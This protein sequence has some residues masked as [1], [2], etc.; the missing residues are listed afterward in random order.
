MDVNRAARIAAASHG[1]QVVVSEATRALLDAEFDLRD[2]GEHRLKDLAAPIRLFQL[3]RDEFPPL[4]SLSR[5]GLPVEPV[6][7]LGRKRELGEVL[8]LLGREQARLV[9]ITGS[10]GIGKTSLAVAAAAELV[11]SFDEGVLLVELAA[12][13]DPA[14]VLPKIAEALGGEADA[15]DQVGARHLLLVLD[16]LEQVVEAAG[17]IARL[18]SSCPNLSVLTTSRET[19]RVAGEREFPLKPLAEAPAVELFRQRAEAVLPH[20][21]ADYGRLAEICRRLDS[22][23]LAIELA[24]A[25]VKVLPPGELLARLDRRLPLLSGSRRDRPERQRTLRATIEWSY[26]LCSADEQQLFARLAVFSG[27]F[28]L[29]AAETVCE[30]DLDML[31]SLLDKS[32][33]R[34][35]GDRF[36]MLETI[37]EYAEERLE[38]SGEA[39]ELRRRHAE[40]FIALAE[41]SE[42]ERQGPG[43]AAV[44]QRFRAEWDNVRAALGWAL[45]SGETEVGLRLAGALGMVWLDQNVAVEGERW[46][47]ALLE[48]AASV[49]DEVRARA[50]MIG[51]TVAGVRSNF[52]QAAL[53]GEESLTHFRATGSELGIAWGLTTMAVLALERGAPEA[54][55]QMLEEAEALHRKLGNPGGV[56]R[57]LHLQGQQAA[58][59]GDVDRGR[60][61]LREVTDLSVEA[62]DQFSAASI[63][64]SLGD[65]D[66]A[67][68]DLGAAEEDYRHALRVAW[69]SRADRLVCYCL[70]GL[71][72]VAAE[73]GDAKRAALLWGFADAYEERLRFTMRRRTLYEERLASL[74]AEHREQDEAGRR[75]DVDSAVELALA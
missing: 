27:G 31:A 71:A 16:N 15:A 74:A 14:L 37:R 56:R 49:D 18:L 66:L 34:R 32:L 63:L 12:I 67:A 7:L 8:R 72:A 75:L 55:G 28:V 4:R 13:R 24:A 11:E 20:F 39:D 46:F 10:G 26:E 29:D 45:A 43:Q 47:R 70:A 57:V 42:D 48:S 51:S 23:P 6:P 58:A 3:G 73:R 54:A 65:L 1:G 2:L 68:D 62:G 44:W 9:T 33:L 19:L 69:D 36:S 52:E 30:A 50:L 35:E 40:Y 22:L 64:H 25:R 5:A 38:Q 61:L 59:V 41:A 17:D 53:W 60:R 21:T